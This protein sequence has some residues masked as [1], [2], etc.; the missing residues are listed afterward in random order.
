MFKYRV[1]LQTRLNIN[2]SRSNNG[3]DGADDMK[4]VMLDANP[5]TL[6][7]LIY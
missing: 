1:A 6:H 4:E 3:G 5:S 2:T 7:I